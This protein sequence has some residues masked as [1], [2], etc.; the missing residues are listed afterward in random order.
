MTSAERIHF[1]RCPYCGKEGGH[2][3]KVSKTTGLFRI[4]ELYNNILILE[5][6][7]CSKVSRVRKM[8]VTLRWEDMTPLE[9]SAFQKKQY[10]NYKKE[11]KNESTK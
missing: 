2:N 8:G 9:R 1:F 7:K 3:K 5:C 6:Q 11:E 4:K 10:V